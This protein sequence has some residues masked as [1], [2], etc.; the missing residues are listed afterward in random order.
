MSPP[1][2]A[3]PYNN[4]RSIS[5][6]DV[7]TAIWQS[8]PV[9][10]LQSFT[11]QP[12]SLA[13]FRGE[14]MLGL[15]GPIALESDQSRRLIVNRSEFELR[16]AVLVDFAGGGQRRETNLG[17]IAAGASIELGERQ[18]RAAPDQVEGHKGPDPRPLLA[19]SPCLGESARELR[20]AEAGRL[21]RAANRRPD[22]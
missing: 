10:A 12:R 22:F 4:E 21:D 9:P 5:G 3:L 17:T 18:P 14:Q 20:R 13:M 15:S 6:E 19:E 7:T 1:Q 11:V 2:L 8:Y 16:D